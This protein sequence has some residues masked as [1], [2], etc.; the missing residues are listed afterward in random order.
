MGDSLWVKHWQCWCW[1]CLGRWK[2]DYVDVD[3]DD[4]DGADVDD[5]DDDDVDVVQDNVL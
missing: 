1:C 5:I 4:V 2:S 3:D